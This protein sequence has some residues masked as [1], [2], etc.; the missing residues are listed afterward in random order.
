VQVGDLVQ[1]LPGKHGYYIITEA[2]PDSYR[3]NDKDY[4]QLLP[5]TAGA[6]S[7]YGPMSEEFIEVASENR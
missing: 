2:I 5:V 3:E 7:G 1:V 6:Y 4:W